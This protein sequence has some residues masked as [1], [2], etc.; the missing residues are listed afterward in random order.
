MTITSKTIGRPTI[1]L[2]F[3]KKEADFLL[4][5]TNLSTKMA[6]NP[7]FPNPPPALATLGA[8]IADLHA[9]QVATASRAK[10]TATVRNEKRAVVVGLIQQ[11]RGYV[12]G[13]ADATP[14]NAAS[15]IE[16]AG[17]AVRKAPVRGARAFEAR[18][19][20][21]SGSAKL[22]AVSAGKRASYEWQYSTDGGKSWILAPVT[23]QAKTSIAGLAV[24]STVQFR[25]RAVLKGGEG[26]WSQTV[27]LVVK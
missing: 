24:G 13:V 2:N 14:E 17:F 22:V 9:A 8:A 4:F 16:S 5:V 20:A 21:V 11:A 3:P 15:I 18:Q 6:N 27:A 23:L 10:G 12:Q 19:G 7:Y 26:D 1:S 25:Y